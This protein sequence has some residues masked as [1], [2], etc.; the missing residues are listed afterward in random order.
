MIHQDVCIPNLQAMNFA[1]AFKLYN[2]ELHKKPPLFFLQVL[3]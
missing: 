3:A 2:D 1:L